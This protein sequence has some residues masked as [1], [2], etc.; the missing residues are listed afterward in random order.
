[1]LRR[2]ETDPQ[3]GFRFGEMPIFHPNGHWRREARLSLPIAEVSQ[4]LGLGV[5][6]PKGPWCDIE[7]G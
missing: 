1:L 4:K 3:S 2:N 7:A 6:V 5:R